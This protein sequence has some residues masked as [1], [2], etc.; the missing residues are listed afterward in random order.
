[1]GLTH[2]RLTVSLARLVRRCPLSRISIRLLNWHSLVEVEA[3][4]F[5]A[6]RAGSRASQ[7]G[8][9]GGKISRVWVQRQDAGHGGLGGA[10]RF[11]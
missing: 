2:D 11:P 10:W 1:M 6:L 4:Y 5:K 8:S 9:L 7:P 3:H